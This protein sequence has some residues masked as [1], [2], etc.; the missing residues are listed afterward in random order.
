MS[1]IIST[2]TAQQWGLLNQPELQSFQKMYDEEPSFRRDRFFSRLHWKTIMSKLGMSKTEFS[3][4]RNLLQL[5]AKNDKKSWFT[6][7]QIEEL[8]R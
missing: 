5:W 2:V 4:M 3:F 6:Q 7:D 8:F 1:A